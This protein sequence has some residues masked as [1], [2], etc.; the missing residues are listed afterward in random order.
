MRSVAFFG[1]QYYST[2][3]SWRC[4]RIS[5]FDALSMARCYRILYHTKIYTRCSLHII[6]GVVERDIPN[7]SSCVFHELTT[8]ISTLTTFSTIFS[9][10]LLYTAFQ[11]R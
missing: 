7:H 11:I 10:T 1:Y 4:W 3:E 2:S 9:L 5:F 8:Y 6:L